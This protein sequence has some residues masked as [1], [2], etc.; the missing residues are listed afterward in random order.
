MREE[1]CGTGG[2]N[3]ICM[4]D[5]MKFSDLKRKSK[6]VAESREMKMGKT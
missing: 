6:K 1:E 5:V 3:S 2:E 4:N